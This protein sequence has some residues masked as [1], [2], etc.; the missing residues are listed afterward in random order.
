MVIENHRPLTLTLS[1]PEETSELGRR[2]GRLLTGGEVVALTGELGA[3]KTTLV[4]G[5]ARGL[6]VPAESQ[7][8][9]PSFVLIIEH[10]G[11]R[12]ILY[13]VDLYRLDFEAAAELGLEEILGRPDGVAAV[14]WSDRA[15]E[16][17]PLD[18]LQINLTWIGP[19]ERRAVI[20]AAGEASERALTSL[21]SELTA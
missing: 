1:G 17:L 12:L 19:E 7:V 20:T 4:Q 15:E 21:S 2:L 16:L 10:L 3:G 14:E 9:S 8:T 5:L 11:G 18:R 6:D 13:H